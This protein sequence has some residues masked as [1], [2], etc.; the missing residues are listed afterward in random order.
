MKRQM[1]SVLTRISANLPM[2]KY[3]SIKCIEMNL[4]NNHPYFFNVPLLGA[5]PRPQGSTFKFH[6]PQSPGDYHAR[7]NQYLLPRANLRT[8]QLGPETTLPKKH[9]DSKLWILCVCIRW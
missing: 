2:S 9:S 5:D 8:H 4:V 7:W 3:R 1:G 6:R